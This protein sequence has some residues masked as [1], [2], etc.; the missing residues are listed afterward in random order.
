MY[1]RILLAYDGSGP[2]QQALL[3]CHKIALWSHAELSLIAVVP[4]LLTSAGAEGVIY[5]YKIEDQEKNYYQGILDAGVRKLADVG[6]VAR[7]ELVAGNR[8]EEIV[9][10]AQ[11]LESDLIVLGHKH[12]D[13]W[14]ARWWQLSVCKSLMKHAPCS[15]LVVVT[16]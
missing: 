11:R 9:R 15:V 4:S 3:D 5:D 2:G 12:R 7:G 10:C 16:H 6:L 13:G 14:V 8:V 1:Q